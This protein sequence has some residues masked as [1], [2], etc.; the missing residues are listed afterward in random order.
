MENYRLTKDIYPS[1]YWVDMT[2][3]LI[4]FTFKGIVKINTTF[5]KNTN[6]CMINS[7]Q[8]NIKNI[9]VDEIC[10]KHDEDIDNE[11][12]KIYHNFS[13][14]EHQIIITFD[15]ILTDSMEGYYRS[16][17][18][19]T[20]NNVDKYIA[21]TQFEST[22]ARNAFPCFD[23]P[24]F[25]AKFQLTM[26]SNKEY[27]FLSNTNPIYTLIDND[28]KTVQFD[29]TPIMSTYLLAFIVGEL[30]YI[31]NNDKNQEIRIYGVKNNKHRMKFSLDVAER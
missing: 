27:T 19:D 8:L 10:V 11:I 7:K 25:K 21:V 31:S 23:E 4:N 12:I 5:V 15:G 17:Y 26:T 2:T 28:Y 6:M 18:T 20:D 13:A 29:E 24:N 3:D 9:K 1:F 30:E 14:G 22:S 16:K